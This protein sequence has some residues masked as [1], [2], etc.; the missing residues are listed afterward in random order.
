MIIPN[1]W[2]NKNVPNYQPVYIYK[3]IK[4]NIYIYYIIIYIYVWVLVKIRYPKHL[5]NSKKMDEHLWS[6]ESETLTHPHMLIGSVA[7]HESS[8]SYVP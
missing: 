8:Q 7:T 6:R 5:V 2:E 1:I 4:K 3:H